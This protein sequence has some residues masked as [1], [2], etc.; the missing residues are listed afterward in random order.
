LTASATGVLVAGLGIA[1]AGAAQAQPNLC[2]SVNGTERVQMGT[3]EC[4]SVAGRNFAMARGD[5]ATARSGWVEGDTGNRAIATGT[6]SYADAGYGDNN[7]A[8][9]TGYYSYATAGWTGDNNTATATGDYASAFAGAGD[10]NTATATG[11]CT[12]SVD[13]VNDTAVSCP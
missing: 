4:S 9:A 7:T 12:V 8:T 1:G 3:A 13:G 11:D 2:I 5:L 6:L 10:N